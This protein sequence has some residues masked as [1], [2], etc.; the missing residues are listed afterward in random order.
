MSPA[1]RRSASARWSWR[2]TSSPRRATEVMRADR[3]CEDRGDLD[4]AWPE[5]LSL[6]PTMCRTPHGPA[7]PGMTAASSR[8][9]P[10]RIASGPG[11]TPAVVVARPRPSPT[12]ASARAAPRTPKARGRSTRRSVGASGAR[13]TAAVRPIAAQLPDR[14]QVMVVGIADGGRGLGEVLLELHGLRGE[15]RDAVEELQVGRLALALE[16][17][18]MQPRGAGHRPTLGAERIRRQDERATPSAA[19]W[20]AGGERGRVVDAAL[21]RREEPLQ[22]PEPVASVAPRIDAVVAQSAGVAPR[23]DRVRVHPQQARGLGDG[24]R[25]VGRSGWQCGRQGIHGGNV[26]STG[27]DYQATSSCQ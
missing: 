15:S 13:A 16:G 7:G 6:S 23:T 9:S 26:K 17:I 18:G 10:G 25:G 8:R 14:H 5:R 12:T 4:L 11:A 19:R 1:T 24:Q 21:S 20:Q 27:R 2:A 22:I 3:G